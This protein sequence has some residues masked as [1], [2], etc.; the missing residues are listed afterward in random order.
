MQ[1][2]FWDRMKGKYSK[3]FIYLFIPLVGVFAFSES[4]GAVHESALDTTP[5][6]IA[7]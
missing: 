3:A 6:L 4:P 2:E 1:K 5:T 7:F